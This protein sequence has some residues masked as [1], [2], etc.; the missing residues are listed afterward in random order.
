M[1]LTKRGVDPKKMV[2]TAACHNCKSEYEFTL[3][4]PEIKTESG[5]FREPSYKWFPCEVCGNRVSCSK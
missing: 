4:D 1:K 5:D 2:F 3:S